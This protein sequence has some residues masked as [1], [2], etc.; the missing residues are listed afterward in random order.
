[1]KVKVNITILLEFIP[2][3]DLNVLLC[4]FFINIKK[5]DGRVYKPSSLTSFQ[6]S[7]Q[8][9][10]NNK[11]S[12]LNLFKDLEFTKSREVLLA[13]KRE[14][15][16]KFPK[17]NLPQA[18]RCLTEAEEDCY[19]KPNSLATMTPKCSRVYLARFWI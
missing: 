2:A 17:G 1:M 5:K 14:L 19:L 6:R 16:E 7:F 18:A 8:C 3:A 10:L 15:V 13:K 9:H 4:R 11:N 12:G